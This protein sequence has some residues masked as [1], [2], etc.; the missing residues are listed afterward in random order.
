MGSHIIVNNE[1]EV[2]DS[3]KRYM[4]RVVATKSFYET[5][6][7]RFELVMLQS[8]ITNRDG[9]AYHKLWF[10]KAFGFLYLK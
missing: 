9:M 7:P 4:Q 8:G 10:P 6:K 5:E 2:P 1:V 3:D